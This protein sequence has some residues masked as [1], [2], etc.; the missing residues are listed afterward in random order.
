MSSRIKA[1]ILIFFTGILLPSVLKAQK[2]Q[3]ALYPDMLLIENLCPIDTNF[4]HDSGSTPWGSMYFSIDISD[5]KSLAQ[6]L[7]ELA[8]HKNNTAFRKDM[9][10]TYYPYDIE[11]GKVLT[12]EDLKYAFGKRI[13]T[14][15]SM[16]GEIIIVENTIDTSEIKAVQFIE[17]WR[18]DTLQQT[19]SKTVKGFIPIRKHLDDTG[20]RNVYRQTCIVIQGTP[21]KAAKKR[22]LVARVKYEVLLFDLYDKELTTFLEQGTDATYSLQAQFQHEITYSPFLSSYSRYMLVD[23]IRKSALEKKL[24]AYDFYSNEKINTTEDLHAGVGEHLMTV[25]IMDFDL[26]EYRDVE[27]WEYSS[28]IKSV[29]FCEEWYI[30]PKT[31]YFSKEV[32]GIGPVLWDVDTNLKSTRMLIWFDEDRMF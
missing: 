12:G 9:P 20:E 8:F 2:N 29:I 7:C 24:P 16:D 31:G 13:D 3:N 11:A 30:N 6:K 19:L 1:L 25:P 15:Y 22:E 21:G 4:L 10:T 5:S 14:L 32:V 18:L 27:I 28:N 23:F 26:G 17:E